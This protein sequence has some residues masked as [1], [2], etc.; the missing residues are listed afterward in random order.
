MKPHEYGVRINVILTLGKADVMLRSKF[1]MNG[2]EV[3]RL[4][5]LIDETNVSRED[6]VRYV[7][8]HKDE[9]LLQLA[10]HGESE[11]PVPGGEPIVLRKAA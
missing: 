9:I 6:I 7:V 1:A 8:E 3:E 11:I 2:F 4:L 10:A 5:S